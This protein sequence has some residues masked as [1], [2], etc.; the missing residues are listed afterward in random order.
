MG[1]HMKLALKPTTFANLA[2]ASFVAADAGAQ[3]AKHDARLSAVFTA[4]KNGMNV[5]G[6]N[7]SQFDVVAA[8][9]ATYATAKACRAL[10][11]T[12]DRASVQATQAHKVYAAYRL[13]IDACGRPVTLKE[14]DGRKATA[15]DVESEAERI[16]A[17]FVGIVTDYLAP[18]VKVAPTAAELEAKAA[19]KKQASDAAE[20]MTQATIQAEATK[21]ANDSVLSLDD[22]ARIVANALSKGMLSNTAFNAI[23][24]ASAEYEAGA[25]QRDTNAIAALLA[26]QVKADHGIAA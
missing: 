1:S 15:E 22:M 4:Y 11:S 21:L 24:D 19:S 10:T 6:G 26:E 2:F 17:V 23:A 3:E 9:C 20:A 16:A 25:E 8:A 12:P 14:F 5:K 18:V 7:A 13:A